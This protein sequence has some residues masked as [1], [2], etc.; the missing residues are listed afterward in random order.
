MSELARGPDKATRTG[1]NSWALQGF[2]LLELNAEAVAY[3]SHFL[4]LCAKTALIGRP[5]PHCLCY[6][7]QAS[8][9]PRRILT[10]TPEI[11]GSR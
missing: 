3:P 8:F 1:S 11:P 2:K 9:E 4:H 7:K 10:P 6:P 5:V